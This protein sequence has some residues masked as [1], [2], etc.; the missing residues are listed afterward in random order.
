MKKL[1]KSERKIRKIGEQ[2]FELWCTDKRL[3]RTMK[4]DFRN[5]KIQYRIIDRNLYRVIKKSEG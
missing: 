2:S 1:K 5:N 4:R 3:I